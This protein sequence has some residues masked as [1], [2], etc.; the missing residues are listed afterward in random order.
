MDFF[1]GLGIASAWGQ[2]G[3]GRATTVGNSEHAAQMP[4][5]DMESYDK[6]YDCGAADCGFRLGRFEWSAGSSDAG[7]SGESILL[8]CIVKLALI[9]LAVF[10]LAF[11]GN[12]LRSPQCAD[13][14][15]LP[16]R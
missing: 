7:E 4:N 15:S 3:K 13:C 2:I 12:I 14:G 10:G 9:I 5:C 8:S 1:S 6:N 16:P 11:L